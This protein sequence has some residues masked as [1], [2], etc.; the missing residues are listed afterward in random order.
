MV[1]SAKYRHPNITPLYHT[2]SQVATVSPQ[3]PYG[4]QI[5]PSPGTQQ[6]GGGLRL[7]GN[8]Q[9]YCKGPGELLMER[10]YRWF[11]MEGLMERY[12]SRGLGFFVSVKGQSPKIGIQGFL[13]EQ[14]GFT[15]QGFL[16]LFPHNMS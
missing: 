1:Y 3:P 6:V 12:L 15:L 2:W 13:E 8:R 14:G 7:H 5:Q 16:H 10:L 4:V 9:F 11:G